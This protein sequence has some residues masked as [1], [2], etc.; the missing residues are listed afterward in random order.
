MRGAV[1]SPQPAETD[2]SRSLTSLSTALSG[3][4]LL[5]ARVGWVAVTL[6]VLS[7]LVAGEY[8]FLIELLEGTE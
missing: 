1:M 7:I 8:L 3:R 2:P 5:L 6:L 4:S